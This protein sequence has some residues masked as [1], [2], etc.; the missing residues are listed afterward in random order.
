M[1]NV[2]FLQLLSGGN[3]ILICMKMKKIQECF[4]IL[5]FNIQKGYSLFVSVIMLK[6]KECEEKK[7]GKLKIKET[8][9]GSCR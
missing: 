2:K 5:E 1:K 9:I 7:N 8:D 6:N 3:D 4:G